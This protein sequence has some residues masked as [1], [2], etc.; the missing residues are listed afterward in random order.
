MMLS[1]SAT[2]GLKSV[3]IFI[4]EIKCFRHC[5]LY[6]RTVYIIRNRD[7]LLS[8]SNAGVSKVP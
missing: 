7:I 8:S 5:F 4:K 3:I 2:N 6:P 1:I